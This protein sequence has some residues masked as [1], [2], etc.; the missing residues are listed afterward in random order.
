MRFS[1]LCSSVSNTYALLEGPVGYFCIQALFEWACQG[2]AG[3]AQSYQCAMISHGTSQMYAL[4]SFMT[5]FELI[6]NFLVV[7]IL[8]TPV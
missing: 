2:F 7:M 8:V 3:H 6:E 4:K 1:S 5:V